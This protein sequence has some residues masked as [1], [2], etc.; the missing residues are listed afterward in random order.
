[1]TFTV[2]LTASPALLEGIKLLASAFVNPLT[3]ANGNPV[4]ARIPIEPKQVVKP[5]EAPA[6]TAASTTDAPAIEDEA[7]RQAQE[8]DRSN[9]T[10]S[11]SATT[12]TIE[13]LRA[14]TAQKSKGEG[15]KNEVK[16]LLREFDT[17][18]VSDM[19][20]KYYAEYYAKV[21]AL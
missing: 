20:P 21:S 16:A 13:E 2:E 14:V 7:K 3:P 4:P 5:A 11:A 6:A 1:M 8:I 17:K 19:D 15:K 10:A 12:L 9:A 18:N